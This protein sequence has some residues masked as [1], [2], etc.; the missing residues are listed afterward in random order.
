MLEYTHLHV[1]TQ[2]SILDGA[3]KI[4]DLM[5]KVKENGMKSLAITDHGNMF[6][7][8]KFCNEAKE[9]GI[10]PIIGCE[11]Y[12]AAKS[13]FDKQG[14][15]NRHSF[16]LI[17]LA[18][19]LQGYKNLSRL[20]SLGYK[21]GFYYSPR[22]DK[23]IL[24]KYSEGLIA[25]SACLGGELPKAILHKSEDQI[26]EV[27]Q[28]FI[29]IF[30]DDFYL[31]VMDHGWPEQKQVNDKI[32]QLA[33]KFDRKVIAT[34]DV[35]FV[36][37]ADYDAHKIL[38]CL[39]TGK[40]L[41]DT[42][43]LYYTGNE[44][45]KSPAEMAELFK[46]HPEALSNTQDIVDKVEIYDIT[47]KDIIL[48][49]FPLPEGF[50][51]EDE[52]LRDLTYK[53]AERVFEELTESVKERLD[54]ELKVIREMGFPGYFLIVQDFIAKARELGVFVGPGRGSAA[55]S[56]VAF[57]TGITNI[58]PIKY[59]LLFER[60]LNPERVSMPDIDI[61]FDDEG[62]EKVM[63]YVVDK[64]GASHVAQIV[65][66]GT[67][68]A[69]MA[70]RDV[71][72]VLKLPLQ[73]AD[74]LAKLV[75]ERPGITLSQAFKEVKELGDIRK[76][77]DELAK[78][79]LTF[80]QTLEGIARHTGTH[81]CGV[82]IG[83][84]DLIEHVP[85]STAK[86]SQLMVTQYEG[87]LVES[88]GLL[89]MDFLGLKTLSII[90]DAIINVKKLHGVVIDID[91][92]PLD[93][94]KTYELYQ[95]A[96]T[97]GTFQFESEGMRAYLKELKPTNIEDLI[98]MNALYRPGPM[99]YIPVYINRKHGREKVNYPHPLL[100]GILKPTNGIMV[101]Q[102][103]IMQTAQIMGGYS[104]GSADILRRAMGKKQA[105]VMQEQKAIF[106]EGAKKKGIEEKIA[107]ETFRIM[108]RF[109]EYGFNRS[110]SAAYS[111]IAYQTA[112]LKAH[113]PAEYMAAVLTHNLNDIKKITFFIDES[114]RQGIP[115]LG[116]DVNESHLNFMV[117]KKGEI[118][119]GMAAIKGVGEA[120]VTALLD[121]RNKNGSF[122]DIVDMVT[123]VNLRAVNK[124]CFEAL[125]MA[126][127]FDCF[128][129]SHR[130]QYF[131]RESTD[132]NI[133]L[134]KIIKHGNAIQERQ[135]SSQVSLFGDNEEIEIPGIE[136]PTALPWS[137]TEQLK[138]EKSVTGFYISGH[139][140]DDHKIV[141][142]NFCNVSIGQLSDNLRAYR[143]QNVTFA[144][145]IGAVAHRETKTGKPFGTFQLEDFNDSFQLAIFS[146]D[147]LKF[148][149]FLV[150][151]SF[152]LLKAKIQPRF[153]S[154]T[155]LEIKISQITLLAEAIENTTKH[156]QIKLKSEQL[157]A[158]FV[159]NIVQL[160][161]KHPGKV[162][163]EIKISDDK[164]NGGVV[165]KSRKSKV[166]PLGFIKS[167]EDVKN[168][169]Y[170]LN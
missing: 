46:D 130:A 3:A 10:K 81:A 60:F 124:R 144:G 125:A 154:E 1:H 138:N 63:Q 164:E 132:D 143:G 167:I 72:R 24:K 73:E 37:K 159:E 147:Y 67:M 19:N 4:P 115:V 7:V 35:H 84:D 21:E 32:F 44:Y 170:K 98:A 105:S 136:L 66:F 168:L 33:E 133:F 141:M 137:K 62:R 31:E 17:L 149:H 71:A 158:E 116:P 52:Y 48:P 30:G 74:R 101:Y 91:K 23:E 28:D 112:Y 139:P 97:I 126:G 13:R 120:A 47:T 2:Y 155:E 146:E 129:G 57:C 160:V 61:D 109:A 134:E 39:N 6:G 70:I 92:I 118:R 114:L 166:D 78:K 29:E 64:Y 15:E 150:E 85:L 122:K 151:G 36:N 49:R 41:D 34:N 107:V 40:D 5:T 123:R 117:N 16:H 65:T 45:L 93:D 68:A 18:K 77:G 56:A 53:G 162:T 145:M 110:H 87:K 76:K 157:N 103:Q 89:K 42:G 82:I 8:L 99:N 54:Y 152:L 50:E 142:K 100:E 165:M 119:F 22:I 88:V 169:T 156:I 163:Y 20:S 55:G 14:K 58:D 69:K 38:I 121:E 102:E 90:K 108:E 43:G 25:S 12:M 80:A 26:E 161:N 140:L 104:L 148:R 59:N 11:V 106:V 9:Y 86:D 27:I 95:R 135:N 128:A 96:E 79:T 113:Y 94:E 75:P 83:P 51:T 153:R 127:G 131:H 111:V